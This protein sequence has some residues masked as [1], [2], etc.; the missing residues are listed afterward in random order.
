MQILFT[1]CPIGYFGQDCKQKCDCP[2]NSD[3]S[4]VSG[5]CK[6]HT[7]FTGPGCISSDGM[8]IINTKEKSRLF[9]FYSG[10][11]YG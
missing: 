9:S 8:F 11:K 10:S 1:E 4:R 3:C 5:E 6:C 7:G 2:K